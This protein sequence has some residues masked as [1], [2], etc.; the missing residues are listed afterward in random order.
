MSK[1]P[2]YLSVVLSTY[3][4]EK[5]IAEAIQSILDQTYPYFE[6]IIVNDGSNDKTLEIIK[7]FKDPRIILIDKPNTGL[8][9]SL[10]TGVLSAKYDW[11]ARMDGDDIAAPNRFEEEINAIE[12][13][14]VIVT[15]QCDIIDSWGNKIGETKF[16][17]SKAGIQISMIIGFPLIVH[18]VV[19]FRK[20]IAL[21]VGL[22]DPIMNISEDSD[23][24]W[25][26]LQYGSFKLLHKKLLKLRKHGANI[27]STKRVE[28]LN[29][30]FVGYTKYIHKIGYNIDI[31][32]YNQLLYAL[33]SHSF[34]R[35]IVLYEGFGKF[36]TLLRLI[37]KY[38]FVRYSKEIL[39]V[40]SNIKSKYE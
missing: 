40:V 11:I 20:D 5:Y 19:L 28:Q 17:E 39:F 38:L 12:D 1:E 33:N 37:V 30:A 22:Y 34:I 8:I 21:K 13:N 26:M 24:W 27:S 36:R 4:D 23:L 7:S 29:T 2:I 3:N 15:S 31:D 25:K 35:S 6:F 18:P 10:N 14:I 9:D 16:S 32:D